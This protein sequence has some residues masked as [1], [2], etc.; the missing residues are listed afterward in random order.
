M[1]YDEYENY[2]E[3][4]N[5][6]YYDEYKNFDINNVFST[7]PEGEYSTESDEYSTFD[8]GSYRFSATSLPLFDIFV[9]LI[10]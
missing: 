1:E 10:Y 6:P 3:Y 8:P 9:S 4:E 5:Y 7:S 2:N